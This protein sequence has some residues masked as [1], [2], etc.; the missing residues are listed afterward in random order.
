M[1][2]RSQL[3]CAVG[4]GFIL[5][6]SCT[7]AIAASLHCRGGIYAARFRRCCAEQL[8]GPMHL[9]AQIWHKASFGLRACGTACGSVLSPWY[10][11]SPSSHPHFFFSRKRSK[12]HA[13]PL[14]LGKTSFLP[15]FVRRGARSRLSFGNGFA[16]HQSV[17]YPRAHLFPPAN[18]AEVF[19][20]SARVAAC[21]ASLRGFQVGDRCH[22]LGRF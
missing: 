21:K 20:S 2:G 3:R 8:G 10:A 17:M 6:S 14:P 15:V 13:T 16:S 12:K 11:S 1:F 7:A 5:P 4:A 18:R 19:P 9:S 22:T